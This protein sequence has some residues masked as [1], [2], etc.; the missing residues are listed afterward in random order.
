V[1]DGSAP[2][3]PPAP[4]PPAVAVPDLP[5]TV[6]LLVLC[7]GNAAR[8]VM[9]GFMLE[10]LA[11]AEGVG[12]RVVTAGTHALEGQPMS[13]RTRAALASVDEL[14]DIVTSR[15]R[16]RQVQVT[17]LERVDLVVAMEVD[18][19]RYVRRRHPGAAA[20]TATLRRLCRELPP[21]PPSLPERVAGLGLADVTLGDDEDVEDPAGRE[22]E[23]YVACARQLF[24]LCGDLLTRL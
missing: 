1:S 23:A 15:H 13:I 21:G 10:H 4:S 5:S 8:S 20:R 12:L 6:D 16:S 19:V 7:T 14:D 11:E 3:S 22:E 24:V 17:D 9:A 18:H 2:T